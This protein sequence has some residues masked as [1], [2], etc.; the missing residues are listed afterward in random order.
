M[1]GYGLLF[2]RRIFG[3]PIQSFKLLRILG[4]NMAITDIVKLLG[5]PFSKRTLMRKPDLPAKMMDSGVKTPA[6]ERLTTQ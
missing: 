3:R 5:S 4:R 6:R 1:K 2:A